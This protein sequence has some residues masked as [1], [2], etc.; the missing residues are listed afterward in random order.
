[1]S[2]QRLQLG[3][4]KHLISSRRHVPLLSQNTMAQEGEGEA[5]ILSHNEE[6]QR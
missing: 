3:I 2:T 6:I 1:M 5:V 4:N